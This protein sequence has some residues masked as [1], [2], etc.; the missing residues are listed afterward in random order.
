MFYQVKS[1][2]PC[3]LHMLLYIITIYNCFLLS[4]IHLP[5]MNK[6][7]QNESP[8]YTAQDF[9]TTTKDVLL[10]AEKSRAKL[11]H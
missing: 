1:L 7:A 4:F 3:R 5:I 8:H 6:Y 10:A 2:Y 11:H 9:L